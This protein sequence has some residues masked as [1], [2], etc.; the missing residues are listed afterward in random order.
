MLANMQTFK[1][2]KNLVEVQ[3]DSVVLTLRKDGFVASRET[4]TLRTNATQSQ[5]ALSCGWGFA[6]TP[7][8][9]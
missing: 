6:V 9:K 3:K 8:T 5:I 7:L 1:F 4:E 2:N